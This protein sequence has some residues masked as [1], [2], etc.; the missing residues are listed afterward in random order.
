MYCQLEWGVYVS[1]VYVHFAIYVNLFGVMLFHRSIV[2]WSGG[3]ICILSICH[4]LLYVK[5]I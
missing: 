4:I 5:L 3:G 1:S 2:N